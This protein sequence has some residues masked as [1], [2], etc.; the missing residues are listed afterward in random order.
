[1][2]NGWVERVG[3]LPDYDP[4]KDKFCVALYNRSRSWDLP[5]SS[6][7]KRPS[8]QDICAA[9]CSGETV[10]ESAPGFTS[11]AAAFDFEH[12]VGSDPSLELVV[13]RSILVRE[14]Y[15]SQIEAYAEQVTRPQAFLG[16]EPNYE[17]LCA[18]IIELLAKVVFFLNSPFLGLIHPISESD[19]RSELGSRRSCSTMAGTH[20]DPICM[21]EYKLPDENVPVKI[22]SNQTSMHLWSYASEHF[23]CD[24]TIPLPPSFQFCQ[25]IWI[26]WRACRR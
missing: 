16:D 10:L 14:G 8:K 1:L 9:F 13:L 17:G 15:L 2:E 5:S 21:A 7:G 12:H 26:T 3:K 23:R 18:K 22:E 6:H 4:T 24:F 25:G 20:D 11:V 19:S